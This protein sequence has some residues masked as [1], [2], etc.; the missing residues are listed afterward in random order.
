[1]ATG[2]NAR[3][4][5]GVW[6]DLLFLGA[7]WLHFV[8]GRGYPPRIGFACAFAVGALS[9]LIRRGIYEWQDLYRRSQEPPFESSL[10]EP[11]PAT[12]TEADDTSHAPP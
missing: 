4:L 9:F 6:L 12:P 5:R 1:M 10:S 8:W 11:R 7:A 2:V 3:L